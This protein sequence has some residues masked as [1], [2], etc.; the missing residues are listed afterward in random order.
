MSGPPD[1]AKHATRRLITSPSAGGSAS[2]VAREIIRANIVD[3]RK[4]RIKSKQTPKQGEQ[5]KLP[6]RE[7][8]RETGDPAKEQ[9]SKILIQGEK[10]K[11]KMMK[12]PR[13]NLQER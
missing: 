9:Q 1:I 2:I 7:R 4:Y 6:Y 12:S 11:K 5:I 8:K 13:R 3:T 10:V